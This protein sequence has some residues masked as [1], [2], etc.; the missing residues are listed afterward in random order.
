MVKNPPAKAGDVGSVP[1]W[2]R[3]PGEGNGSP[4]QYFCVENPMERG[5]WQAAVHGLPRVRHDLMTKPPSLQN[6]LDKREAK[7]WGNFKKIIYSIDN[8]CLE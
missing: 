1:G 3:S 5:T 4:L 7:K 8:N 2:G 6:T